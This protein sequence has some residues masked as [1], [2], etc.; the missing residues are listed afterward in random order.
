MNLTT[1]PLT[2]PLEFAVDGSALPLVDFNI[3]ESYAGT[4]PVTSNSSN[5]AALWFWFFPSSNPSASDEITIWLNGG[6]GCSSLDG[7]LQENGPF[8]WQSG[9][10]APIPNPYSWVN[11]TNMIWIDQPVGTGFAP[12]I[13]TVNNELDVAAQFMVFWKGFMDAFGLHGRKV[14]IAGESYAG[15]YIPYIAGA[16]LDTNDTEYFNVAGIQIND[17]SVNY[18]DTIIEGTSPAISSISVLV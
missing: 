6:P 17:P 14:Y 18:D 13:P 2:Y 5:P 12:G 15:Q 4:I 11:L 3:G 1:R 9:T 16:M 10:Y 7:L 8:L